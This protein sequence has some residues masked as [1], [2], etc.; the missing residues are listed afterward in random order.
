MTAPTKTTTTTY[1]NTITSTATSRTFNPADNTVIIATT[2]TLITAT[3]AANA[4]LALLLPLSLAHR[5]FSARRILRS[6]LIHCCLF[7]TCSACSTYLISSTSP[8]Y[9]FA[10]SYHIAVLLP[11]LPTNSA[12][13]TGSTIAF[14]HIHHRY[15]IRPCLSRNTCRGF[16]LPS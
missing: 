13:A 7:T 8:T 3:T 9:E 1:S 11:L 5:Y 4:W 2:T 6:L 15:L 16:P 12:A 14:A 10:S